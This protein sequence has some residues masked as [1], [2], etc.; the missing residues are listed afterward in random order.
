MAPMLRTPSIRVLVATLAVVPVVVLAV[1]LVTLLAAST[2]E[3]SERLGES[4]VD[5]ATSSVRADVSSFLSGAVRVSDLY[6]R[7]LAGGLLPTTDLGA[8]ERPE[9]D[10]LVVN[11]GVASICFGAA[12]GETT[13]LLRR[14]DHLEL[15]CVG[16]DGS[17]TEFR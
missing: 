7:R 15:G 8:W 17:A 6:E 11:P 16:P 2:R 14:A 1:V 13:W 12:S 5:N 3:I 9:L 10:D 4:L